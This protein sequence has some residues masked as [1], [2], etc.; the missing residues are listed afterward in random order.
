[1]PN[2]A[3]L[4]NYQTA[5]I[6]TALLLLSVGVEGHAGSAV[7]QTASGGCAV[8]LISVTAVAADS[9]A[10]VLP[11]IRVLT[12]T[13]CSNY[14]LTTTASWIAATAEE[15]ADGPEAGLPSSGGLQLTPGPSVEGCE[16]DNAPRLMAFGESLVTIS[17]QANLGSARTGYVYIGGLKVTV[18][19]AAGL[20]A[21]PGQ[22]GFI[23]GPAT[24]CSGTSAGYSVAAVAG[25][26]SYE[27]MVN[28]SVVSGQ[29]AA[30]A[31]IPFSTAGSATV[32]VVAKNSG[33][34]R[35]QPKHNRF[36]G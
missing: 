28:G 19:Q 6:A 15:V 4:L 8:K 16:A 35:P 7:Q 17:L 2:V 21:L 32:A 10:G 30:S 26:T 24:A 22:P 3:K 5:A 11:P 1:M 31:T 27:W 20:P 29:T 13:V 18:N 14:T 34:G 36:G 9:K 25:A 23:S 33:G 12:Y